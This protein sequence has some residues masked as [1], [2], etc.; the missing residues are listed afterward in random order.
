MF[1]YIVLNGHKS[2][3]VKGL[4]IQS[5]PA[6]SKPLVRTQVDEIDGRDGDI[7]T[8]LGYS[9]YDKELT[10]GLY[11]DFDINEIIAYF[12]S[13]GQVIFSNEPDKY[14]NYQIIEQIDF[15]RLIRF[16]TATVTMHVQPFKFSS[17]LEEEVI[18]GY[19]DILYLDNS[20][21]LSNG[22][23]STVYNGKI[24]VVG[25][26][27]GTRANLT[28]VYQRHLPLGNYV[29]ELDARQSMPVS[30][31]IGSNV[32]TVKSGNISESIVLNTSADSYQFLIDTIPEHR[33]YCDIVP[34]LF[35]KLTNAVVWNWGNVVSK[36]V[37]DIKGSGMISLSIDGI[38]V[39]TL[40]M[41]NTHE[42]ILDLEGMNAFD[43]SGGY[44]N[45]LVSGNYDDAYLKVGKNVI[46][47]SGDLTYMEIT[48]QSRW[49]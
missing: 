48:K 34:R 19:Y 43:I 13:E 5:L 20:S 36:P 10:V 46:K 8:K 42:I 27:T 9:A 2:T 28:P 16:R 24:S 41:T 4:L 18:E 29:L 39:F 31:K 11:G 30:V 44:A 35:Y 22:I 40:D 45:R 37:F 14:Y 23:T 17:T 6:I 33:Y 49:L 1:N 25:R 15:E 38:S 26:A 47:W 12:D 32:Y 7:V 3:D 21:V